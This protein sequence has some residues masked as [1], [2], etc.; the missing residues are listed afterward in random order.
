MDRAQSLADDGKRS[1]GGGR[2]MSIASRRELLEMG[3]GP[4]GGGARSR[5]A[6]R[7]RIYLDLQ[8]RAPMQVKLTFSQKYGFCDFQKRRFTCMGAQFS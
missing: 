4:G 2:C 8:N 7:W 1:S 5:L 6:G 3:G